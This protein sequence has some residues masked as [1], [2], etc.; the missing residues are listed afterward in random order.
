M[1]SEALACVVAGLRDDKH[2][3]AALHSNIAACYRR[4]KQPEQAVAECDKALALL[5][6][7]CRALFRR[8]ACLLEAGNPHEAILAFESL[9][10]VNRDW[11][12]LSEWLLRAHAAKR[13]IEDK[14]APAHKKSGS[15]RRPAR[16]ERDNDAKAASALSEDEK[17]ARE[18]D[19]YIVLGVTI[20]AT[21]KQLQQAYRMRSLKYHPDRKGGSTAAFQRIA[22]AFQTLSDPEKRAAYDQG[23]DVK[24]SSRGGGSGSDSEE[25]DEEHKKTLREEIERHYYPERYEFLPFGDP[26]IHKRKRDERKRRQTGRRP[27]YDGSDSD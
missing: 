21:S 24:A 26:F 27:W 12:R 8:A 13:R 11:P 10:R 15:Y 19:H 17:L 2:C 14:D 3:R 20:D 5:P 6:R 4:N 9:Y 23:T 16:R 25:E 1:Y 18:S 22:S 7:F